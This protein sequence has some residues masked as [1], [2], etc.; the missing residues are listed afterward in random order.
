MT[1]GLIRAFRGSAFGVSDTGSQERPCGVTGEPY[2]DSMLFFCVLS[3]H[4]VP[5]SFA[6]GASTADASAMECGQKND[7]I[8][9]LWR[10]AQALDVEP[11]ALPRKPRRS[12]MMHGLCNIHR[13]T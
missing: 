3:P 11:A 8:I 12:L 10:V 7:A 1:S 4:H 13:K 2:L 9:A 5:A 6:V